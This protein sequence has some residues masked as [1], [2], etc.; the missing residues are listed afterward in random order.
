[1]KHL[2]GMLCIVVSILLIGWANEEQETSNLEPTMS[3]L[4]PIGIALGYCFVISMTSII[5]RLVGKK[6]KMSSLQFTA[7]SMFL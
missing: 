3:P 2:F 1:M 5:A 4:V 6:P 7:D